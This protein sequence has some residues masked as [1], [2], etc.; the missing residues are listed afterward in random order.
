[1]K[2]NKDSLLGAAAFLA[3]ASLIAY[4][5]PDAHRGAHREGPESDDNVSPSRALATDRGRRD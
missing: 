1:M 2:R 4:F 5:G 3:A